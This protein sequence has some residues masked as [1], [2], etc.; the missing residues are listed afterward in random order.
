MC[1]ITGLRARNQDQS[2]L[3]ETRLSL[4]GF[5]PS[6]NQQ[7]TGR[8]RSYAASLLS[9]AAPSC[10]SVR[11]TE[12]LSKVAKVSENGS[13]D[14]FASAL[15]AA[16]DKT[17]KHASKLT[18][19]DKIPPPSGST[20]TRYCAEAP[21]SLCQETGSKDMYLPRRHANPKFSEGGAMRDASLMLHLLENLGFVVN[22]DKSILFPSQEMEFL[23]VLVSSI[24]MSFSRPGSKVL[25][26]R[27]DCRRLLSSRTASQSD[28]ARLIGKMIAAKAAVFQAP[29][30]YRALQHQKVGGTVA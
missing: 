12:P 13:A 20:N 25:N 14:P 22:M 27:N 24:H 2:A 5:P 9:V 23:G 26:L 7:H 19:V 21:D 16:K 6:S 17:K 8:K 29:L 18:E 11:D 10:L 30:H 1:L 4:N 3:Q 15:L 28:L